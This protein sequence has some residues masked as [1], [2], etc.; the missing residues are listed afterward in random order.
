MFP[1]REPQKEQ[2]RLFIFGVMPVFDR[3]VD[4]SI[5]G[6]F[7]KQPKRLKANKQ[8]QKVE[9]ENIVEFS[10]KWQTKWKISEKFMKWSTFCMKLKDCNADGEFN[11]IYAHIEVIELNFNY[12]QAPL[13][14]LA[15]SEND[16]LP[17]IQWSHF[18]N[19]HRGQKFNR[20]F[21]SSI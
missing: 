20:F 2:S 16:W 1:L 14:L 18:A 4:S 10:K 9:H 19:A 8:K 6:I 21:V 15:I 3:S 17:E 12:R 5:P 13:P 7:I 11:L